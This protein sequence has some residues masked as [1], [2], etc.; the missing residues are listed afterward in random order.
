M[1]EILIFWHILVPRLTPLRYGLGT[2]ERQKFKTDSPN[3]FR[4]YIGLF[5]GECAIAGLF[6]ITHPFLPYRK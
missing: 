1:V 6:S 5:R 2:G 4:G 3:F